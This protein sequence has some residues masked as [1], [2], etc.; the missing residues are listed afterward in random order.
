[1]LIGPA[2]S[3]TAALA[4]RLRKQGRMV[5]E[6]AAVPP[7]ASLRNAALVV[8]LDYGWSPARLAER[9]A[10]VSALVEARGLRVLRACNERE[11]LRITAE[12]GH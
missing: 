6:H 4:D 1:M 10:I 8:F 3:R 9:A 7:T 5:E 11:A 2:R 12:D